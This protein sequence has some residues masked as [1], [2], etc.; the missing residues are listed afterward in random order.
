MLRQLKDEYE[1]WRMNMNREKTEYLR[2]GKEEEEYKYLGSII[3]RDRTSEKGI[4]H[5]V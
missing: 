4:A 3:S 5:R 2:T 1:K